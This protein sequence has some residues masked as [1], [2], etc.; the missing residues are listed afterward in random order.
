MIVSSPIDPDEQRTVEIFPGI[1]GKFRKTS[2]NDANY[3]CLTWALGRSDIWLSPV[4]RIPP[5]SWPPGIPEEWSVA[6][7]REI[8]VREG[9]TEETDSV[10]LEDGWEKVAFFIE[11]NGDPTH[12][13]RQL[14]NG[15]WT[16][17]LGGLID[18]EHNNLKCLEGPHYGRQ[19]LILKREKT[20]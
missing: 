3:N 13:S 19:G 12:F 10:E 8:F 20:D 11:N 2:S 7:I 17:K 4:V 1:A 18:I 5:Y 16:S 15:K 14:P 6:A 9:Y